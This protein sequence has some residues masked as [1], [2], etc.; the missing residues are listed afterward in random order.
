MFLTVSFSCISTGI[1]KTVRVTKKKIKNNIR[2]IISIS[3]IREQNYEKSNKKKT[4]NTE[5]KLKI[6][7]KKNKIRY[8]KN[9][10]RYEKEIKYGSKKIKH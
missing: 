7:Y 5:Q 6:S 3:L 9:K 4:K 2:K 10:I 1:P 8:E